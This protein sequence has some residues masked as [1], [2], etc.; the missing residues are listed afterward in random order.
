MSSSWSCLTPTQRSSRASYLTPSWSCLTLNAK[1][2]NRELSNSYAQFLHELS[3]PCAPFSL[4]LF[5]PILSLELF[6]SKHHLLTCLVQQNMISHSFLHNS[7]L[8][9][10]IRVYHSPLPKLTLYTCKLPW[11]KI[12]FKNLV[13]FSF[14]C[15]VSTIFKMI[16]GLYIQ[17]ILECQ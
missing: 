3:G 14:I 15:I 2:F 1:I 8:N 4:G 12:I 7:T 6:D 9:L 5:D 11:I 16:V 10:S 13:N 17:N